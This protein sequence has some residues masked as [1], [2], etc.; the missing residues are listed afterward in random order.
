MGLISEFKEFAIRGNV[1]DLAVGVVIGAAFGKIVSSLV[2]DIVMPLIGS[3]GG[4]NFSDMAIVL[5]PAQIG[6]DGKELAAAV[7]LKYGAFIQSI[8]DFTLIAFAVFIA[9]KLV[10]RLQRRQEEIP[11]AAPPPAAEI[12]LLTEIRDALKAR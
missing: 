3:L 10:N 4:V 12:V 1:I 8:I 7:L 6:S 5:T 2:G 9:I 11:A